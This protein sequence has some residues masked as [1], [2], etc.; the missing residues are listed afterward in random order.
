MQELMIFFHD[1][2][3]GLAIEYK[4]HE[5]QHEYS[6]PIMEKG[7]NMLMQY[8]EYLLKEPNS[9]IPIELEGLNERTAQIIM[10]IVNQN[11]IGKYM[12]AASV[13]NGK[14]VAKPKDITIPQAREAFVQIV[15]KL[16]LSQYEA[17]EYWEL[18][19]KFYFADAGSYRN[20]ACVVDVEEENGVQRQVLMPGAT[21]LEDMIII[22]EGNRLTFSETKASSALRRKYGK[23][24]SYQQHFETLDANIRDYIKTLQQ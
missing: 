18:M 17:A 4:Q 12:T 22:G 8:K 11:I 1:K 10:T 23:E 5:K 21:S 19:Q 9:T 3:K 7:L 20:Q 6:I 13:E 16:Q 15:N 2:V 24:Y 14:R